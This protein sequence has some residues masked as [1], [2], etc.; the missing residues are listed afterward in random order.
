MDYAGYL[1]QGRV[2]EM[3]EEFCHEGFGI[4]AAL[5]PKPRV[6]FYICSR[7]EDVDLT[8]D[9]LNL[10]GDEDDV[11]DVLRAYMAKAER[12]GWT[13]AMR[14]AAQKLG[15]HIL[16]QVNKGVGGC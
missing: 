12:D 5:D 1:A 11:V 2:N 9:G 7:E 8:R 16:D 4:A 6:Y 14:D 3:A 15:Q 13:P 10:E